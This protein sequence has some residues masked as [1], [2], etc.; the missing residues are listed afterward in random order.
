MAGYSGYSMSNNA[1]EAYKEGRMPYSKWTKNTLLKV[2]KEQAEDE[3]FEVKPEHWAVFRKMP[4]KQL[5]EVLLYE[6][7]WH[8]TSSWYNQTSFYAID[9]DSNEDYASIPIE[10]SSRESSKNEELEKEEVW[11]CKYLEWSGTRRHPKAT[12]YES[13]GVIKG[14]WFYMINDR[15]S[16]KKKSVNA[17]GFEK[18]EQFLV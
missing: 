5:R 7:E 12:E 9:Y 11:R 13:Y 18:V 2:L 6:S 14:N 3:G 15:G 8:H 16:V 10:R 17:K 4:V 1:V